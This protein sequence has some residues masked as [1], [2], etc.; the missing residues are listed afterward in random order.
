MRP[1][2]QLAAGVFRLIQPRVEG[3]DLLLALSEEGAGARDLLVRVDIG[4]FATD[5]GHLRSEFQ[6]LGF[7]RFQVGMVAQIGKALAHGIELGAE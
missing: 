6:D 5:M 1:I 3:L 2:P 4:Q 7:E